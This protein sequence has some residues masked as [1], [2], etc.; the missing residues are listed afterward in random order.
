MECEGIRRN[1]PLRNPK[2]L[3]Y[4]DPNPNNW[5]LDPATIALAQFPNT[6]PNLKVRV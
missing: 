6:D 2:P 1:P 5:G 4:S 3:P